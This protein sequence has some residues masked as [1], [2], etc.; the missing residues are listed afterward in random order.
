MKKLIL[1][2]GSG[3]IRGFTHIGVLKALEQEKI[4]VDV[5]FGCSV[6]SLIS[7]L[8][9]NGLSPSEIEKR[10]FSLK[11][12]D[13]VDLTIPK[14]GF[15]QGRKLNQFIQKNLTVNTFENLQKPVYAVMTNSKTGV[16]QY[17]HT[18]PIADS[19][20]ASCSI[21]GIFRPKTIQGIEYVDGDLKSPVPIKKARELYP[22]DI[23]LGVNII[24]QIHDAPRDHRNWSK[25]IAKDIYRRS[26]VDHEKPY[27]DFF[28]D[29]NIGFCHRP[30]KTWAEKQIETG[31]VE[32]L[33]ICPALK[34]N[35]FS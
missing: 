33:K 31:F 2:L 28:L 32:T 26:L 27:A 6:G 1:A 5:Y 34:K 19:I 21:P 13:L 12:Y 7:V 3:G 22:T 18:G 30:I 20:Q 15:I 11:W 35:L 10:A 4:P 29:V 17:A 8:S 23:I 25:W 14:N 16:V 24:S 9:A